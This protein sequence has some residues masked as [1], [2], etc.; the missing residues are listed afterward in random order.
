MSL[1]EFKDLIA[2]YDKI[3]IL[4]DHYTF[5]EMTKF[6]NVNTYQPGLYTNDEI[7]RDAD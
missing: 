4:E 5:N 1:A 6:G 3:M 7:Q 2:S